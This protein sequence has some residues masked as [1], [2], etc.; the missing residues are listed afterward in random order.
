MKK[1]VQTA[2]ITAAAAGLF[3]GLRSLPDIECGFLHYD[4]PVVDGDGIEY[5]GNDTPV[6]VE[7]GELA[8]PVDFSVTTEKERLFAG[9][10]VNVTLSVATKGGRPISA[11]ELAITH[12][13][14][15]HVLVVD[16]DR[17]DYF[18]VHPEPVGLSGDWQFEFTPQVAGRYQIFAEFVPSKTR[19]VVIAEGGLNIEPAGT[20]GFNHSSSSLPTGWTAELVADPSVPSVNQDS[21]LML[22]I[23]RSDGEPAILEPVMGAWAHLVAFDEELRGFAHL[24]PKYTGK[25]KNPSPEL[26]FVLNTHIPGSYR[27]WAQVKVDGIER[28]IP[29]TVNVRETAG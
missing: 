26:E 23:S 10:T 13:E 25:E 15:M 12:T 2:L 20:P 22:K 17:N 19:Q 11:Q 29:F 4:P 27:I 28:F 21:R 24:H 9:Q 3:V 8:Y 6:F 5:C 16:A 14:L 18:H 1:T 7:V